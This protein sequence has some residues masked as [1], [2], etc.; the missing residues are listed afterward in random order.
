VQD[1]NRFF[2]VARCD[3][4]PIVEILPAPMRLQRVEEDE[5]TVA[6]VMET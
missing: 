2:L 4:H 1:G 6:V 3:A 5:F